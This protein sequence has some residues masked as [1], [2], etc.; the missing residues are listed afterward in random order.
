MTEVDL[1]KMLRKSNYTCEGV[2]C[3][4]CKKTNYIHECLMADVQLY[5]DD[6]LGADDNYI[7]KLEKENAELKGE[8]RAVKDIL[9]ELKESYNAVIDEVIDTARGYGLVSDSALFCYINEYDNKAINYDELLDRIRNE[10]IIE[11]KLA[12]EDMKK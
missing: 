8:L 10:T 1:A 2:N 7:E 12:I 6:I 9:E 11:L 4:E 5:C 3:D